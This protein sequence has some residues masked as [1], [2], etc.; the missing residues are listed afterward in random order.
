MNVCLRLLGLW[1][2]V[3]RKPR[4]R[5]GDAIEK[6]PSVWP[7]AVRIRHRQRGGPGPR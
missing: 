3:R 2:L 1:L 5:V 7:F 4:I 6:C